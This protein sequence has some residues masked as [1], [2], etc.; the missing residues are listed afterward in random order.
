MELLKKRI[1]KDGIVIKNRIL[2]VDS[3]LNHQMDIE[4]FN[5][6]GKE[7]KNRFKHKNITKILTI[8]ASGIGIACIA[9]QHFNNVPV[10]FAK[11]YS[12]T[13]LDKDAYESEVYSFTKEESYKIRVSK[14]YINS[15]DRILIIDDFLASGSAALGLIDIIRQ[16]GAEVCGIGIVIEKYFQGG[17]KMIEECGVY[18]ESLAIIEDMKDNRL[19]FK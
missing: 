5:E 11:K 19:I 8:E 2:K 15:G 13:N 17:R 12:A 18:L 14:K 4:L 16:A 3:F 7:F 10:I 9:A 1:L 6:I